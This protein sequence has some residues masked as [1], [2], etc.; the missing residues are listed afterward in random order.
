MSDRERILSQ[1]LERCA[2][3]ADRIRDIAE[4]WQIDAISEWCEQLKR[5]VVE[6]LSA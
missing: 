6:S 4:L 2:L 1:A 3:Y 5:D